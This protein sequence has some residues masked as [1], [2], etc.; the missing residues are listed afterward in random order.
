MM[1]PPS[2]S[3]RA[4]IR[5]NLCPTSA[6]AIRRQ[7]TYVSH[8]LPRPWT[9]DA[10]VCVLISIPWQAKREATVFEEH[11]A[12]LV[13][14]VNR[15]MDNGDAASA[16]P[17]VCTTVNPSTTTGCTQLVQSANNTS[18]STEE[19]SSQSDAV[20]ANA[21]TDQDGDLYYVTELGSNKK[22]V[23]VKMFKGTSHK[24]CP[25]DPECSRT[26]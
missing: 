11:L 19:G 24:P 17:S 7:S 13:E 3:P 18:S 10:G 2:T 22:R 23:T 5:N 15:A 9:V 1:T 14:E 20:S 6:T 26:W 16:G 25:S 12:Q 21:G 4:R 8:F